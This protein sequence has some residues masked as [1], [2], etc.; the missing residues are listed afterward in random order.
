[1]STLKTFVKNHLN[2]CFNHVQDL[3]LDLDELINLDLDLVSNLKLPNLV[4]IQD[5]MRFIR[6]G[7][8]S[9]PPIIVT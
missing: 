8:F 5:K 3:G 4:L 6:G 7:V 2:I 1:M 9:S